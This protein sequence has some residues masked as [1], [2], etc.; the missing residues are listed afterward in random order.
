MNNSIN[1][2]KIV[3]TNLKNIFRNLI[4]FQFFLLIIIYFLEMR[5]LENFKPGDKTINHN[6][7]QPT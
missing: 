4:I 1:K 5:I 3:N 6:Y 2:I 7:L